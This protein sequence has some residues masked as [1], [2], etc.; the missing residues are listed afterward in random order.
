MNHGAWDRDVRHVFFLTLFLQ[1][2]GGYSALKTVSLPADDSQVM[3]ASGDLVADGDRIGPDEDGGPAA[4]AE[5]GMF[6]C[7]A[8]T[9]NSHYARAARAMM[10]TAMGMG[11]VLVRLSLVAMPRC[12]DNDAGVASSLL[13]NGQQVGGV[14]RLAIMGTVAWERGGDQ[15]PLADPRGLRSWQRRTCPGQGGRVDRRSAAT[16]RSRWVLQGYGL[17]PGS[18]RWP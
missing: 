5:G 16:H 9:E 14:D 2:R 12:P 18:P 3:V 10:V 13:N 4:I 8:F 6:G 15:H 7:P 1:G 17:G 11:L